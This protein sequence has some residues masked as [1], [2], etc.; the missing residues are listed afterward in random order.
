MYNLPSSPINFI[1][2]SFPRNLI[3]FIKQYKKMTPNYNEEN[4]NNLIKDKIYSWNY[5]D[6]LEFVYYVNNEKD[7]MPLINKLIEERLNTISFSILNILSDENIFTNDRVLNGEGTKSIIKKSNNNL[8]YQIKPQTKSFFGSF[9]SKDKR[10]KDKLEELFKKIGLNKNIYLI[11]I[12]IKYDKSPSGS[13]Q[14]IQSFYYHL[15]NATKDNY[16]ML[17]IKNKN[18]DRIAI[19][20]N[21]QNIFGNISNNLKYK[22]NC[23]NVKY[24]YKENNKIYTLHPGDYNFPENISF[25]C[26]ESIKLRFKLFNK[27]FTFT[28]SKDIFDNFVFNKKLNELNIT[29][30]QT[31]Y[32][33]NIEI[34]PQKNIGKTNNEI[35]KKISANR[36]LGNSLNAFGKLSN[37]NKEKF[38]N[39][40]Q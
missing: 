9:K 5:K 28:T 11:R 38:Y 8:N 36:Q 34:T 14:F 20:Y 16:K 17:R 19:I 25:E 40:R 18:Y 7:K 21:C 31:V 24:N 12:K 6:F 37:K 2:T 26:D 32:F 23:Q 29:N 30:Y 39:P 10:A 4:L 35:I 3:E 22:N 27:N 33:E 13:D 1:K 15:L